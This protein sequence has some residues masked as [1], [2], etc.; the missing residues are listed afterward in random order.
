MELLNIL[1]YFFISL[2]AF[3][4][5]VGSIGLVRLPDFYTRTHATG[6]SDTLGILLF[7]FGLIFH[8]ITLFG[9]EGI[10]TSGNFVNIAKMVIIIAFVGLTNPTATN[11]LSRAAYKSKLIP[12][13]K[14]DKSITE[15][16]E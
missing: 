6:K 15:E 3:F 11:A 9:R 16:S 7:L 13:F 12:W 1:A 14:G 4:L 2:G 8:M 5:L 10:S